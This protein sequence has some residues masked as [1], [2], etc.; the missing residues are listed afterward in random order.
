MTEHLL[1]GDE[2]KELHLADVHRHNHSA[3]QWLHNW[4]WWHR[5]LHR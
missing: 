2:Y 1:Y 4:D 5:T 3:M